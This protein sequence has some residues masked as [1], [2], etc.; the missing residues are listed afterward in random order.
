V[1]LTEQDAVAQEG[2]SGAAVAPAAAA[3]A[4]LPAQA[5]PPCYQQLLR[6]G[7]AEHLIG[8]G[9]A[10]DAA[11]LIV[12][13]TDACISV[14]ARQSRVPGAE[15]RVAVAGGGRVACGDACQPAGLPPGR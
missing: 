3:S 2:E 10:V 5:D 7:R 15:A 13:F 4:L 8:H 6:V 9:A 14:P 12:G 11:A 1:V